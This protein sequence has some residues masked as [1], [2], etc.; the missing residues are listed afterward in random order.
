MMNQQF[1]FWLTIVAVPILGSLVTT[2]RS[3]GAII[4]GG[5]TNELA[6]GRQTQANII[7]LLNITQF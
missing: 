7:T 1:T 4:I 6:T 3:C 5:F 2:G